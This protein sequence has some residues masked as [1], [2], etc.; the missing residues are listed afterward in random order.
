MECDHDGD[1]RWLLDV[2]PQAG[3]Q[4]GSGAGNSASARG[5][6]VHRAPIYLS[7]NFVRCLA[8]LSS[9][10]PPWQPIRPLSL[11]LCGDHHD[12]LH[13]CLA[14]K[15]LQARRPSPPTLDRPQSIDGRTPR[16]PSYS[17]LFCRSYIKSGALSFRFRHGDADVFYR[18]LLRSMPLRL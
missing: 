17:R 18:T 15:T 11:H 2:E 14:P 6:S 5:V 4:P 12:R 3:Q 13:G 9:P 10:S 1:G 16:T 8:T 7:F